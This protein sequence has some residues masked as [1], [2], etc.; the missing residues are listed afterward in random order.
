MN[1]H[2]PALLC[3]IAS[4]VLLA[5]CGGGNG[6]GSDADTDVAVPLVSPMY[7]LADITPPEPSDIDADGSNAS[8]LQAP[9]SSSLGGRSAALSAGGNGETATAAAAAAVTAYYT[10]A[11][12]RAAYGLDKLGAAGLS[13]R[14]AYQGSGQ[15]IAIITAFHNPNI[16]NDLAVFSQKF[17][18]AACSVQSISPS[19][20][21]PLPRAAAGSGCAF[22]VVYA[23]ASG[24][25]AT[26]VPAA[27][28]SWKTESSLDVEWAHA[29]APMARIILVEA[30]SAG[31]ADLMGAITLAGRLGASVVSMS[32]GSAEYAGQGAYDTVFSAPGVT[33]V[34]AS[35][36]NGRGV[37]WPAVSS[38]VLAVGG[39]TL[40]YSAG[41]RSETAWLGSGGGISSFNAAPAWQAALTVMA[42]NGK[43]G[44][45]TRR[46]VPDV[47]F[48]A[49]P[50]S[51]QLIYVTPTTAGDTGWLVAGGTS[52]GTPQWAGMLA[53]TNAL[54][55][56]SGKAALGTMSASLYKSVASGTTYA[57]TLLDVTQGSN[58]NCMGCGATTGYDLVTGL[59]TPN[60]TGAIGLMAGF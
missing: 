29:I 8:A 14:G 34:A 33:Y 7:E 41:T 52:I 47:A 37:S 30:A 49:N 55:A 21:M 38:Q 28:L 15:T 25:M 17:G 32:F 24:L 2:R 27:N 31:G 57:A 45:P 54:R 40:T 4:A 20:A 36:D 60:A 50:K 43:V 23:G 9:G 6:T 42:T 1:L 12:I 56:A 5:A 44:T 19:A 11:Q 3:T 13:N 39:S 58:G 53:V 26:Q 48:N 35:G 16:A 51:G 46:A 22:S 10:P 18:L 59:G